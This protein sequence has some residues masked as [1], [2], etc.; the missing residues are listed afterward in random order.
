MEDAAWSLWSQS[1]H[2]FNAENFIPF[3]EFKSKV[4]N[5]ASKDSAKISYDEVKAI[6]SKVVEDYEL[7][8]EDKR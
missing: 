4:F 3:S 5:T 8:E 1:Y 7:R 6:M 2:T